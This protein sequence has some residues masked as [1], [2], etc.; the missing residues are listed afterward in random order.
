MHHISP[1]KALLLLI[2]CAMFHA[3]GM[4][5]L[6]SGVPTMMHELQ[7]DAESIQYILVFFMLGTGVGQPFVG[8]FCDKFGRR[9]TMIASTIL[10]ILTSLLAARAE[11]V[12]SLSLLRFLEGLGACGTLVATFAIA[13]DSFSGRAS[14]R[15]FSLIGGSLALTPMLAPMLGVGLM[16]FFG[17]WQACFYFLAIFGAVA[18]YF[19]YRSLPETRPDDTIVP[20]LKNFMGNY[21]IIAKKKIFIAY[22]LAATL[23]LAQLYLY[24]SV[25]NILLINELGL[26]GFDFAL[27]FALN[28]LVFLA[29][30]AYST[31]LQKTMSAYSIV[32]IGAM[33][34]ALGSLTMMTLLKVSHMTAAGI[35]VPNGLMTLGVGLM[36]GPA[37]GA[38]LQ[39]F[40]QLAGAAAGLFATF[41]YSGAALIGFVATRFGVKSSAI[42]ATPLLITACVTIITLLLIKSS[43]EDNEITEPTP[44]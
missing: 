6:A 1:Y 28:A 35:I 26:S 34:I 40:K 13:N 16:H 23:A 18:L 15:M 32:M 12:A 4:D 19:S 43:L 10:F 20:T 7:T 24:F 29:G 17:Y 33:L 27:I 8:L 41:Q 44:G 38:A 31:I 37:T 11:T 39:P 30:N 14:Y 25:G 3:L 42:I 9:K 2:P 21:L 36:I 5:I 22:T